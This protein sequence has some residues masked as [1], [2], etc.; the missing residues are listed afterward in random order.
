M[1]N[2]IS[3]SI[4][5]ILAAPCVEITGHIVAISTAHGV[6]AAF[7]RVTHFENSVESSPV[8][9]M[10]SSMF[11]LH[12]Q[13]QRC[14]CRHASLMQERRALV[15]LLRNYNGGMEGPVDSIMA[16]WKR[17][18][19]SGPASHHLSYRWWPTRGRPPKR[20]RKARRTSTSLDRA[21]LPQSDRR[22]HRQ[23]LRVERHGKR[24][25]SCQ[26]PCNLVDPLL[27]SSNL[28]GQIRISFPSTCP[29]PYE[30]TATAQL[31]WSR[32]NVNT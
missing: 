9:N 24:W 28:S 3:V 11:Q 22:T 29:S 23:A 31:W 10:F 25:I 20:R 30:P 4:S 16:V 15:G 19:R 5:V 21:S 12:A 27:A 2:E 18:A 17:E 8:G 6:R 13:Q 26:A 32:N 7:R 1:V 14:T